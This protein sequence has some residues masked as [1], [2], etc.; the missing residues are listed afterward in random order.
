MQPEQKEKVMEMVHQ[1]GKL[2]IGGI[3]TLIV[4]AATDRL[5][6]KAL[7]AHRRKNVDEIE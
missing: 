2:V 4:T 7:E 1:L 6:D 5:Y 3:A